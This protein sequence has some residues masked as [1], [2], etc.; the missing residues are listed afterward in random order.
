ARKFEDELQAEIRLGRPL[1]GPAPKVY[2]AFKDYAE[3][4]LTGDASLKRSVDDDRSILDR[5]LIPVFGSKHLDEITRAD[6][7]AFR[8]QRRE[9]KV[10][11][12][13]HK[14]KMKGNPSPQ[15]VKLELALL[16]R[17]FN[18]AI[19]AGILDRNPAKGV[20]MPRFNNARDRVI[21]TQEYG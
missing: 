16:R 11:T 3:S 9:G 2:P 1:D 17:I 5:A 14:R 8:N 10:A 20:K 15:T 13:K 7:E 19:E 12:D 18:I 4:Y 6:V 21:D